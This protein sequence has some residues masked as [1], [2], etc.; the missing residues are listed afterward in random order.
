MFRV[1]T[2]LN[3]TEINTALHVP[4]E[5]QLYIITIML[6]ENIYLKKRVINLVKNWIFTLVTFS[7]VWA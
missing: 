2:H 1:A 3:S 7:Y 6:I 4:Y 5:I